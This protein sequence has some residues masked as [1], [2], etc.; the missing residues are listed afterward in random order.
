M[1]ENR[2][3]NDRILSKLRERQQKEVYHNS[4]YNNV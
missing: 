1:S 4:M 2:R 3:V